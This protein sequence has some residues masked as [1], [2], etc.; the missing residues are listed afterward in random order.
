MMRFS[1][2]LS[3]VLAAAITRGAD[4]YNI[5]QD[6]SATENPS[7][8]WSYGW[9]ETVDGEFHL[10]TSPRTQADDFGNIWN[11]WEYQSYGVQPAFLYFPLTNP[12]TVTSEGGVGQYPPGTLVMATGHESTSQ[13]FIVLRF[14]APSRGLYQISATVQSHLDGPPSGDTDF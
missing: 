1:L 8:V 12:G 2:F 11:I 14:T 4:S 10:L 9:K 7:G 13:N 6:F 5:I 3:V